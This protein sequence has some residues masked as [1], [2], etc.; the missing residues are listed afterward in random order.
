MAERV[1][2]TVSSGDVL[3]IGEARNIVDVDGATAT[4]AGQETEVR[5]G[6]D[7][8]TVRVPIGTDIV[9]GSE[10]GDVTLDGELGAVSVTTKSADLRADDVASIDARTV[11]GRLKVR[12]SRG[13]VRL[14]TE[15]ADADID[16]AD[17]DVVVSAVSGRVGSVEPRQP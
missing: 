13:S 15:S 2:I 11:S 12:H 4:S 10:S 17:G 3:V 9:V 5:G 16:R 1:R 8:F 14:K 6:S 7:D